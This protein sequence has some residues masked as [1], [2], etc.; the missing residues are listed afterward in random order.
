MFSFSSPQ[1]ADVDST[2]C[3]GHEPKMRTELEIPSNHHGHVEQFSSSAELLNILFTAA[4]RW[5][6]GHP[7]S[8]AVA[9]AVL[10]ED[11]VYR[12]YARLQ[13]IPELMAFLERSMKKRVEGADMPDVLAACVPTFEPTSLMLS[14]RRLHEKPLLDIRAPV[15]IPPLM[16]VPS[17]KLSITAEL[18]RSSILAVLPPQESLK[19][20]QELAESSSDISEKGGDGAGPQEMSRVGLTCNN[21]FSPSIPNT[22]RVLYILNSHGLAKPKA[23]QQFVHISLLQRLCQLSDE[24]LVRSLLELQMNGMVTVNVREYKVKSTLLTPF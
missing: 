24:S 18:L 14:G 8:E 7:L 13:R 16:A 3:N 12:R 19:E 1:H 22:V 20:I 5:A 15:Y 17:M 9:F 21:F 6:D 11:V 2:V 4:A 23:K 10:Y